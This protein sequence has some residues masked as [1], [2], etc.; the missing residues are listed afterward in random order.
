MVKWGFKSQVR[1]A[2]SKKFLKALADKWMRKYYS[3]QNVL[4]IKFATYNYDACVAFVKDYPMLLKL[5]KRLKDDTTVAAKKKDMMKKLYKHMKDGR[6]LM[7][8]MA[9]INVL[10]IISDYQKWG[11]REKAC[12]FERKMAR[13]ISR[14]SCQV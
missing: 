3:L 14:Q 9:T 2:C 5:A 7:N 13:C 12:A 4:E 8:L 10:E 1:S 11:Q 6:V